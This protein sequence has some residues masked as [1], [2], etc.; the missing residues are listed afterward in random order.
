MKNYIPSFD[1]FLFESVKWYD[2]KFNSHTDHNPECDILEGHLDR[3][4]LITYGIYVKGPNTGKEFMEYY[5]GPNY[6]PEAV[7]KSSAS[8]Y[9]ETDKI[10]TKYRKMWEDLRNVYQTDYKGAKSTIQK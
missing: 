9:Y 5:S 2:L 10:P 4:T 7:K 8:R 1:E 3:D 6:K